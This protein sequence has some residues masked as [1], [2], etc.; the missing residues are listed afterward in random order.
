MTLVAVALYAKTP[1]RLRNIGSW[2]VKE[3]DRIAAMAAEAR[4]LG[5]TVEEGPDSI[6]VTPPAQLRPASLH[7]YDDHPRGDV[8][9]ADELR[10]R[11]RHGRR[12]G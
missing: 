9:R 4:K 6:V 7:T 5:A 12:G 10:S 8:V 1:T 11:R 3:T 2:R